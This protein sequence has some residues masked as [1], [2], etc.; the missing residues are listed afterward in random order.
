MRDERAVP[1]IRETTCRG[2][3]MHC[4]WR[5]DALVDRGLLRRLVVDHMRET[6]HRVRELVTLEWVG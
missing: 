3:C 5:T 2:A 6:R 1:Q 4:R